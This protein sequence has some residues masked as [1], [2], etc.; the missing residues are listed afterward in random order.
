ML[1]GPLSA[2]AIAF[3]FA[4]APR[5]TLRSRRSFRLLY[6]AIGQCS[7][8]ALAYRSLFGLFLSGLDAHCLKLWLIGGALCGLSRSIDAQCIAQFR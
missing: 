4:I 7:T 1:S 3:S 8:R 2:F 6:F 5:R